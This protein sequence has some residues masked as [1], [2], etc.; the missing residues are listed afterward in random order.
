[1][2]EPFFT[3]KPV[4]KGTG[5]GLAISYSLVR[6]LGGRIDVQTAVGKGS[7]FTVRW[8]AA[9]VGSYLREPGLL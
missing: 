6:R 9:A 4:G 8:P 5:L 1:L 2:F 3:T 7:T